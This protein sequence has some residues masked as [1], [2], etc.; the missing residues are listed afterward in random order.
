M[1]NPT[2]WR[3]TKPALSKT[4]RAMWKNIEHSNLFV[5]ADTFGTF[6]VA[7]DGKLVTHEDK[8]VRRFEFP[9]QAR[10]FALTLVKGNG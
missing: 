8:T 1:P 2:G 6:T 5:H 9:E 3:Y 7:N 10:A 4:T